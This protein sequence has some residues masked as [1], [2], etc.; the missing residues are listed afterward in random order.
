MICS[1]E[2]G[3]RHGNASRLDELEAEFRLVDKEHGLLLKEA[4]RLA[5]EVRQLHTT[6]KE[7]LVQLRILADKVKLERRRRQLLRHSLSWRV[8]RPLRSLGRVFGRLVPNERRQHGGPPSASSNARPAPDI[9]ARD[10][11]LVPARSAGYRLPPEGRVAV[12]V[13]A[14]YPELF[15]ELLTAVQTAGFCFDLFVTCPHSAMEQIRT[16]LGTVGAAGAVVMG[17]ANRGRDVAPFLRILHEVQARGYRLLL[18]LHTKQSDHRSDGAEWRSGLVDALLSPSGAAAAIEALW[19]SNDIGLI[20]PS[21]HILSLRRYP[22]ANLPRVAQ[23][24]NA[25]GLP[26]TNDDD[27]PF[28]AGSMF[29]AR[30]DALAPLL[31][32]GLDETDFEPEV[33]QIDGTLAHAIERLFVRSAAVGGYRLCALD[34]ASQ[35]IVEPVPLREAYRFGIRND[36]HG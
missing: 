29:Y 4:R 20:G 16:D 31:R 3:P 2:A 22:G 12:V 10:S 36:C 33:G 28:V 7:L 18:K 35:T 11:H 25:M 23:L 13:H 9:V 26:I 19:E 17:V 32:L 34:T 15:R 30:F 14:Y 21:G 24:S 6:Q 27:V 5:S 8:T 1:D